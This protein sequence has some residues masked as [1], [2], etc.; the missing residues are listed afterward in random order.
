MT[1]RHAI[2]DIAALIGEPTRTAMLLALLDGNALPAGEL[3]TAAR[4]SA[5]AASIHLAKLKSA[6]LVRVQQRGR[7]RYYEL[8]DANVAHALEALGAIATRATPRQP[9][10]AAQRAVRSARSCYDHLAGTLAIDLARALERRALLERS[11][12]EGFQVTLA[13]SVWLQSNLAIDVG[14]LSRQRRVLIRACLDWTERQPHI[15]G[16]V[17]AAMLESFITRRWLARRPNTRSLRITPAG[18]R[19]FTRLIRDEASARVGG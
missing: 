15:A 1:T 4:L 12:P 17:G 6:G 13:G 16:A 7:H 5:G 14:Q 3:A 18:E 9:L 19:A 8:T 10:S 2:A 11:D